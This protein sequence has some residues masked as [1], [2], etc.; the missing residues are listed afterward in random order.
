MPFASFH[1]PGWYSGGNNIVDAGAIANYSFY[2][3]QDAGS[4][5]SSSIYLDS[6]ALNAPASTPTPTPTS[7]P[8]PTPTTTTTPTPTTTPGSGSGFVQRSGTQFTLDGKPYYF[9]GTNGYDFF[10]FGDGGS[11]SSDQ[12]IETAYMDKARIDAH[13]ARLAADGVKVVR[14]WGFSHESWHG[15][16]TAKG[17]YNEPEFRLFDYI[18]LS[19]KNHNIKLQVVFENY[20]EAYGGIDKRLSW[21]GLSGGSHAA[22]AQFFDKTKC[23]G[24]FQQYKDYVAHMVNRVNHYTGVKYSEDPTI[25]AWEL[26]NEPRFQD[27]GENTTGVTLRKWV[28]EMGAYVKSL[29]AHH[30]LTVGL[31]GHGTSYGFGGD[32]GNPFV[33]IHQSPYIDFT[34]AHPYP[35]EYWAN[36]SLQQTSN[37]IH[38]YVSDS[39]N[40]VGKPFVM[41][42]FNVSNVDRTLWWSTIYQAL[43]QSGADGSEFWWYE[44]HNVDGTY[45]VLPG[46]AEL[47]VFRQHAQTMQAKSN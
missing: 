46:A 27:A 11:T 24:C 44:D 43:E 33:Y 15:F 8:T 19:A 9:A 13:M 26:M 31:E 30:L 3:N 41:A 45:G 42:E 28:D 16:E 18:V 4:A 5:G 7:T 35:T 2:V 40:L 29:D 23:P 20:W 39:H 10:T 12:A 37:L 1:H 21:E 6:F 34:T 22:R 38:Q 32:E 14:L 25:F 47:Q 36:L 17:V